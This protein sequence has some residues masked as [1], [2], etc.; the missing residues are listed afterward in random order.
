MLLERNDV[1]PD[2][3][4]EWGET[5]LSRA[6]ANG[7]QGVM[8]LLLEQKK[9]NPDLTNAKHRQTPLQTDATLLRQQADF[10]PAH[11]PS[12]PQTQLSSPEPSELSEP[13]SK[14]TRRF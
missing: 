12:H 4:D 7:H 10:I 1:D 6:I 5:P 3:A 9:A 14:R 11:A 2:K 13:S 8:K